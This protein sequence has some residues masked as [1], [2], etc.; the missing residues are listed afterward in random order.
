MGRVRGEDKKEIVIEY[1]Y[2][3][4][5]AKKISN[6]KKRRRQQERN[7]KLESFRGRNEREYWRELKNLAGLAKREESLPEVMRM[8]ER[9]ESGE[10]RKE[11]WNEGFTKLG[12]FNLDDKNFEREE[13]VRIRREVEQ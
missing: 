8:G 11:I 3:R 5:L 4:R 6:A 2:W 13:C 9:V 12:R 1:K 10:G 7:D